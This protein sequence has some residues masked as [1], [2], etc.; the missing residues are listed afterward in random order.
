MRFSRRNCI[1][2]RHVKSLAR[3]PPSQ[4]ASRLAGSLKTSKGPL[5]ACPATDVPLVA[6]L[7][8]AYGLF[9]LTRLRM[10]A[11]I[12]SFF[13]GLPRQTTPAKKSSK[14]EVWRRGTTVHQNLSICSDGTC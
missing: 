14:K 11:D 7:Q 12:R 9:C 6:N 1:S 4:R 3:L 2:D 5:H 10:P 13:G 8:E